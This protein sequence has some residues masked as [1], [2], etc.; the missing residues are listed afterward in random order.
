MPEIKDVVANIKFFDNFADRV[1]VSLH[2]GKE[3]M[4][5]PS[6]N[7]VELARKLI[8]SGADIIIRH[9]PHVLQ[10]VKLCNNGVI[11]YSLGNFIFNTYI[12]MCKQFMILELRIAKDAPVAYE[13]IPIL[14]N[15]DFHSCQLYGEHAKTAG[16]RIQRLNDL[17][18]NHPVLVSKDQ[19]SYNRMAWKILVNIKKK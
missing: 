5:I 16:N 6:P 15:N 17:I 7:Q 3:Y 10:G 4:Y 18:Q 19:K 11:A 12:N 14:I 9:H 13:T 1:I 2:W 8:D